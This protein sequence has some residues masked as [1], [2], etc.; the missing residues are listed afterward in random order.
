MWVGV[1]YTKTDTS[2]VDVSRSLSVAVEGSAEF[3]G[4]G[5]S[6]KVTTSVTA[7]FSKTVTSSISK[8]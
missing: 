7:S 1:T 3:L 2:K 6:Y 5:G 8:N 4:N